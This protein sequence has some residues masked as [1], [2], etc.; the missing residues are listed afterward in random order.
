M[1]NIDSPQKI[2]QAYKTFYASEHGKII[3]RDLAR[4]SSIDEP[5]VMEGDSMLDAARQ[6]GLH[7]LL[8]YIYKCVDSS[9]IQE[10][11]KNIG[12]YRDERG[13]GDEE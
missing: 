9:L 7:Q 8:H 1:F 5:I 12:R 4:F 3:L 2:A 11:E 13:D 6:T 10:M